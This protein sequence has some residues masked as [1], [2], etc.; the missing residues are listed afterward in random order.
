MIGYP[1][2]AVPSVRAPAD[3]S[4]LR[5]SARLGCPTDWL[6]EGIGLLLPPCSPLGAAP[7]PSRAG[8]PDAAGPVGTPSS[9]S[10]VWT[11]G[12]RP[13]AVSWRLQCAGPVVRRGGWGGQVSVA[14]WVSPWCA[15]PSS[16]ELRRH[17]RARALSRSDLHPPWVEDPYLP[18]SINRCTQLL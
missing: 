7:C 13:P 1:S 5:S 17:V 14:S 4:A 16:Q 10:G 11:V 9:P 3:T 15:L 2:S 6:R 12:R 8:S 18:R